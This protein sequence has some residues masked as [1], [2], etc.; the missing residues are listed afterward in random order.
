MSVM[1]FYKNPGEHARIV[2]EYLND[3]E[4]QTAKRLEEVDPDSRRGADLC[5]LYDVVEFPTIV[6]T[7]E[8]GQLRNSWR[9]VPLPTIDEVNYYV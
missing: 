8:D 2:E 1:I 5:R 7:A 6:A 9:G 4:R 3:F